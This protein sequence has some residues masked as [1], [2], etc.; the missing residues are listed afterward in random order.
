MVITELPFPNLTTSS[1]TPVTIASDFTYVPYPFDGLITIQFTAH[2]Q[3]G[4]G[5]I[6]HW[7]LYVNGVQVSDNSTYLR[8]VTSTTFHFSVFN[9]FPY[10][11]TSAGVYNITLKTWV[12]SGSTSVTTHD[13]DGVII[14]RIAEDFGS[15]E[16]FST[17]YNFTQNS[18]SYT[19]DFNLSLNRTHNENVFVLMRQR[20]QMN[21]SG[22][23]SFFG[24][25]VN[26]TPIWDSLLTNPSQIDSNH[27]NF[28]H[29][30]GSGPANYTI[31]AANSIAGMS[32]A[33]N[34]TMSWFSL[35]DEDNHQIP[36][37]Q[38]TNSSCNVTTAC[39]IPNSFTPVTSA[40]L[41]TNFT[42]PGAIYTVFTS[43]FGMSSGSNAEIHYKI[44]VTNTNCTSPFFER[45]LD[46]GDIATMT[47]QFICDT[48][49]SG[50]Q[51]FT[52]TLYGT[53][54][55]S[56]RNILQYGNSLSVIA[57]QQLA[58]TQVPPIC[59]LINSSGSY[60]LSGFVVGA[61][62]SA[63]EVPGIS[64][65]CIK[66]AASNVVFDCKG[67]SIINDGTA[68]AAGI[69]LNG[70]L[71]N[72]TVRNCTNIQ[73]YSYGLYSYK[74]SNSTFSN[75]QAHSSTNSGFYVN[76][77]SGNTLSQ[78]NA[79]DS[80]QNGLY[81]LD[82]NN[83]RVNGSYFY[84]NSPDMRFE[85]D[86]GI[87]RAINITGAV[88]DSAADS[89][90][91]YTNISLNDS[92][93]ASSAYSISWSAQPAPLSVGQAS[94]AGKFLNI[95]AISATPSIDNISFLWT[96]VEVTGGSYNESRFA[97]WKYNTSGW[98]KVVPSILD[99]VGNKISVGPLAGFSVFAILQDNNT[100]PPV[101]TLVSPASNAS[102]NSSSVT[103][104]F[105]ETDAYPSVNCS[106]YMDGVSN[107]TNSSVQNATTTSFPVSGIADGFH[108]WLVSCT[109]DSGN[110]GNSTTRTFLVDTAAPLVTLNLPA[111]NTIFNVTNVN[112]NFTA[113]DNILLPMNCKLFI[114][115]ALT[116]SNP[117]TPNNTLTNFFVIGVA[118]GDH[119][120]RV[121][122]TDNASNT[123]ISQS[124]NFTVD[125]DAPNVTLVSPAN[126]TVF[127]ISSVN[128]TFNSTDT[129]H[130]SA[131]C[132]LYID[133]II[134]QV[135]SS[136]L[137]GTNTN[138][139]ASSI[140]DG[141]HTWRVECTDA[142]GFTGVSS[143]WNFIVDTTAP[144]VALISPSN[145]SS[146]NSS[147]VT[148]TFQAN[149]TDPLPMNCSI[150]LDG[151][152]NSTNASVQST[153]V[154]SF[155]ISGISNGFHTWLVQCKD[156]ANHTTNSTTFNFLVDTAAPVVNLSAPANTTAFSVTTVDFSFNA[157][158]NINLPMTCR[159]FIDNIL[160]ATNSSTQNNTNTTFH[161]IG[162]ATGFHSWRVEC[163]D[164]AS[165]TGIS[166]TWD[167]SSATDAPIV[168]LNLPSNAAIF[169]TPSV[170]FNFTATDAVHP[171]FNC[172]LVLDGVINATNA[173]TQNNTLTN[174][175][176]GGIQDGNHT[177]LVQC[178]DPAG[179][180][181]VNGTRSFIVDTSAP[182][183]ALI[184]PPN[185]TSF[186]VSSV[187]FTFQANDTDPLPMNC[188]IFLDGGLNSTNASVQSATV[189]SFPI[190]GIT[191]G[192]H[193]WSVQCRDGGNH[194]T[195]S[196]TRT[197]LIDTQAPVVTLNLPANNTIFN[198]TNVNFNFTAT[199]NILLPM[200]C[201]LYIDNFL[202]AS[203][204]S[205]ANN[206]LT[207][208]FVIGVADGVHYWRVECT[209]NASNTGI[210]QS[211]NFTVDT[212]APN[213]TLVSPA[214][215]TLFNASAVTFTFNSTD[216]V[217]T[218]AFCSLF[219]D[220][221]INQVNSSVLNG[222]NTNFTASSIADGNHTWRVECTDGAG[223]TGVSSTW[224]FIVDTAA[225]SV[226]LISPA[227]GS[228]TN[229]SSV[230]F[231]FQAND[232]DPL[233]MNCS[234]F[235]DGGLNSTNASV[236][237]A[238]V[239]SFPISGITSGFHTWLVQCKD[240]AN[241][242]T[243]STTFTLLVDT[244]APVVNLSA[245]ANTTAFSV[246]TVD[247]SFNATDNINLPM[248][249]RLYIDNVLSATNS[250]TQNNTN[251]TFH[252]IGIAT[253]FHSWRVE[254]T[255]NASNTGISQTWEF[256]SATDAPIVLLNLPSDAAIFTTSSVRFN[257]TATDAVHPAFNCS[258][259]LDGVINATNAS[260]QNNTL[261]TFPVSSIQDGNH[262]WLVQCTDP[263]GFTGVNGTRSFIVDTTAPSLALI[264]PP[265]STSFNV[266]TV[267]FTFQANDTDPLP[268]NCSILLDG[269]VNQ[270]NLTVQS[271]L[272]T[273]FTI[274]SI[275]DG[276]HTW[277]VRCRDGGNHTTTSATR[278][279]L[280]DTQA[281]VVTLNLPADL[282]DFGVTNINFNFTATDNLNIPMSCNLFIDNI[283]EGSNSSVQNNTLT[284]FF[285]VGIANGF[286]Q[287]RVECT[288]NAS[289]KGISVSRSFSVATNAPVV[290]LIS[291]PNG[292]VSNVSSIT[293]DF[294]GTDEVH[295][296]FNCSIYLDGILNRT[297]SSTQNGTTTAFP[298]SGI[299]DGNHTWSVQ[300]TDPAN[301]TGIS[302]TWSFIV[303]TI[304]PVVGLI[305]PPNNASF[306][307]SGVTFTFEAND[308]DPLPMNCSIFLDGA[309]NSTNASVQSAAVT[310]FPIIGIPDGF[311][312]WLVQCKDG[313][314]RTTNSSTRSFLVDTAVPVVTL[315]LPA[316][317]SLFS[318]TT[319]DFS[320]N[321]TDNI[322]LPM[323]CTL[324]I[325]SV[326]SAGNAS[327]QNS[328][329]TNLTAI[330]I[331]DGLHLWKVECTDSSGN[332]G[333]SSTWNFTDDTD[334]PVVT[335]ISPAN[336]SAFNTSSVT[337]NFSADDDV[338][339]AFNCSMYLD[340][341]QN[342]TNSSTQN[343]TAT[344]F[345]VSGIGNGNHTWRV[346]CID[347]GGNLGISQ[348][349]RF[350]VN[351]ITPPSGGGGGGSSY[352]ST[353]LNSTCAAD[354]VTITSGTSPVSGATVK[355]YANSTFTLLASGPTDPN[356]T[357]IFSGCGIPVQIVATKSGYVTDT[358]QDTLFDC[359]QCAVSQC[360]TTSD[361]P[362][363]EQCDAGSCVPVPCACGIV[364]DHQCSPYQ[365]C[366][367][368]QCPQGQ[369]CQNNTCKPKFEC[370]SDSDCPVSQFCDIAAGTQ[371]GRCSPVTGCGVV[372]D[373]RLITFECGTQPGCPSC[374][375]GSVCL[376]NKCAYFN[377]DCPPTGIIGD[378]ENCNATS[379]NKP[380]DGCDY[381]ITDPDGNSRSGK[382]DQTGGFPVVLKVNGEYTV[383]IFKNGER[384]SS[385]K[386]LASSR[387]QPIAPEK[388]T[389]YTPCLI[390]I[391][392]ALLVLLVLWLRGRKRYD[393][394]VL[395][396]SPAPGSPM[397][398]RVVGKGG[399]GLQDMSV[400]ILLGEKPVASGRTD[401]AG[402]YSFN[403]TQKGQYAIHI[404]NAKSPDKLVKVA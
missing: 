386:I 162:I 340:G 401:K 159:L 26:S 173:S 156:G 119:Y 89:F 329:L 25:L 227:N 139:T 175:V 316:S 336:N 381:R 50:P 237:S 136:V 228:S 73:G 226:A 244:V 132:S 166:Q 44:N 113:T 295:T 297:N 332:T 144:S 127:T 135:N 28:I 251:T 335:L 310:P 192:F 182:A 202:T 252:V 103:F 36:F 118:D 107:Q 45:S 261:T 112:F 111:N 129:V 86:A 65:T 108:T 254:C 304:A 277:S 201:R 79:Y 38:S 77:A 284:N 225:P 319:I 101:V 187:T 305:S 69:V 153:T 53:S 137:N 17:N 133:G 402:R 157:T 349:W 343:A 313:A 280:I 2:R 197:F 193:T 214:I 238:T 110:S 331:S 82:S 352:L 188:S 20:M 60:N 359:A 294:N 270:T 293:F 33:L 230:T 124:R 94:F 199:D 216:T 358:T 151:G 342:K 323:N 301:F 376:S 164:N 109:D 95:S 219:I 217:H 122:C 397:E 78:I 240:G 370:S 54:D 318:V 99:T 363:S 344:S 360:N 148:F 274:N 265:N 116:A 306:N 149:D 47:F 190:S 55:L 320:F 224:N 300:C 158:D 189:T 165:N 27:M 19:P 377:L 90:T 387:A 327:T 266:S 58:V 98:N 6:A 76:S 81:M 4:S 195:T 337:F 328:T 372:S 389:D 311:H 221:I 296:A 369:S 115:N 312:T 24:T 307:V 121:E 365:C 339:L 170:R 361:C 291:P 59:F 404:N 102:L 35:S 46:S 180:T 41:S 145:G 185:S 222:T 161:V 210:S 309:Q 346:Q 354:I 285:V 356:G 96:Q 9:M 288:D 123:G 14:S 168:L 100:N 49:L 204:P 373:H 233:P 229:S 260:T 232:T 383:G 51:N 249:C 29:A 200:N 207:N 10:N 215:G 183:L 325:D 334:A 333:V 391:P 12:D 276:S 150:F 184:S 42:N 71:N 239:T 213:V 262:T 143:T 174:F 163:T 259:V 34:G 362:I 351:V 61:P 384:V 231:T 169:T 39:S 126:G 245:P 191:S 382:A 241:H 211:W 355:V 330:G 398:I 303:D 105:N 155:P 80:A 179:F 140:A 21:T 138:F 299:P 392:L 279:F 18:T 395:T 130:T 83:T 368:S 264:S 62:L 271:G 366:A 292:F 194:T 75:M 178:T 234:I 37:V 63:T 16:G 85:D 208:F 7:I 394:Q 242:T 13:V 22:T 176:V 177:W 186:N 167:F 87:A 378:T 347:A 91:N 364:Q 31:S 257:F 48:N 353:A 322:N 220:G 390:L 396:N 308:T 203:N 56:S 338:H 196:A 142:A 272:T 282:T 114:D 32:T 43:S 380:C 243:N 172:S 15:L 209:D 125:T 146:T 324:Y 267:T 317:G 97:L 283:P 72:V 117:S 315:N 23:A 375:A 57:A 278:T 223:F 256:S 326:A 253:G 92:V 374:P 321:A 120:W 152:L 235:L 205:T 250:S 393:V 181:G 350:T 212:D 70:S 160:S 68:N 289:N 298:V 248:T 66:I 345:L 198:V 281:P 64:S 263:A 141:N 128:L 93:D 67:Y 147:S 88:F 357:F 11:F 171:A 40:R 388:P 236:Q 218:N 104:N 287:W 385:R 206:T 258:L 348:T 275:A 290:S 341:V 74:S 399:K 52:A 134:N 154:T 5:T 30:S 131:F 84:N 379:G 403:P 247:F 246:T 255:D 106:L 3:T 273:P 314:N 302:S 286:H 1:T 367:D 371:G 400:A 268:M 8:T 269:I